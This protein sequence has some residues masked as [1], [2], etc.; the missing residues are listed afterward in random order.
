MCP[1]PCSVLETV[2]D[3]VGTLL[4]S[5]W[6]ISTHAWRSEHSCPGKRTAPLKQSELVTMLFFWQLDIKTGPCLH[7][8]SFLRNAQPLFAIRQSVV[9]LEMVEEPKYFLRRGNVPYHRMR[10]LF[11]LGGVII[12][13]ARYPSSRE[14]TCSSEQRSGTHDE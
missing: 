6:G 12:G 4:W 8:C 11:M 5:R 14:S 13:S 1:V 9:N 3:W 2:I 10:E 7:L